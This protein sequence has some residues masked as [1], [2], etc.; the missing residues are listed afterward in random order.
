MQT[1][2]DAALRLSVGLDADDQKNVCVVR[3]S[4][5][6]WADRR[7]LHTKKSLLFLRRK[8]TGYNMIEEEVSAIGAE[9]ALKNII[10]LDECGDGNYEVIVC[11]EKHDWESGHVDDYNLKL[12]PLEAANAELT[13]RGPK[14]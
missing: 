6:T 11:N 2:I 14:D 8:C 4:T 5:T 7:G 3:I 1:K 12:I 9:D 13:G 10:N